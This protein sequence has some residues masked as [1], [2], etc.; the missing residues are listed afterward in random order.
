MERGILWKRNLKR[1]GGSVAGVFV[2]VFLVSLSLAAVLAV[3]QSGEVYVRGELERMGYGR[4]TAWVSGL[5]TPEPLRQELLTTA[6]VSAVGVQAVVYSEYEIGGQGSDSEGQ[7]ILYDPE[8]YPY[9]LFSADL[10]GYQQ[11]RAAIGPGELY[12]P[13]SLCSM[14]GAKIGDT[15]TFSIARSGVQEPFVIKGFF[16]DPFMGSS[17]IGMKSFLISETDHD[18]IM[19]MIAASGR[20]ALARSGFMLHILPGEEAETLSAA[21]LNARLNEQTSLQSYLEFT[22]SA[23]AM[24]GFMLTLQNVFAG[25]LLAFAVILILAA[26]V[27]LG[28]SLA[29]TIEQ[30]TANM[31]LLKTMG[32]TSGRLRQLQLTQYLAGIL[33]GMALGLAAAR[34][35]ASAACR[36]MV[37]TTGVLV[38]ARLPAGLCLLSLGGFLCLLLG[39]I[40]LKTGRIGHITPLAAIRQGARGESLKA[41]RTPLRLA[42]VGF[43]LALRQ[44]VTGKKRYLGAC[45]VAVL[46]VFFAS[47]IGR[48]NDWLGPKGEGLMDAFNPAD[49]HIAIQPMGETGIEDV[50]RTVT[51]YTAITGRYML[52]MPSVAVNGVDYTANV[53]TEPQ[54][55]HLLA[56]RT[57]GAPGEVVLTEFVAADL[58]VGIGDGVT[59]ASSRGSREYTVSGIYQCANDL[60]ANIGMNREGYA[61]IGEESP[62]M[63]CTHYFLEDPALG[64]AILQELQAVYGGDVAVHENSWPGLTGI[65]AAM[66]LL[67]IFLYLIVAVFVLVATLLTS[68]KL[69][70]AEQQDLGIYK[71][72]G[73]SSRRLRRSFLLRFALV[74]G[75]GGILGTAASAAFTDLLV[76]VLMRM[77]G[78]SNFSSHPGPAALLLP[79]G[80]VTALFAVFAWLASSRIKNVHPSILIAE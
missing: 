60:G 80:V 32:F 56:G 40:W 11:E 10:A 42:P 45:M 8:Q 72:L 6:E 5:E 54:R 61:L 39:F 77:E 75:A 65:L 24:A 37:S 63:W 79:G 3:W 46:L 7:L 41:P 13:A 52:A 15:I 19:E 73:F 55:F 17:M 49:L 57:C 34:P 50:E 68:A 48:V 53:I 47:A 12:A 58:G 23:D 22:H 69:L 26:L 71:A 59:V 18:R 74:A 44:L 20:N 25:L 35:A 1:H 21:A 9:R 27:V 38:P 14:F 16:E 62:T 31:G 33:P 51:G 78:I 66:R 67:M 2:L 76:A 36:M 70:A 64:P 28:H 29:S 43:W 30:D 4:L